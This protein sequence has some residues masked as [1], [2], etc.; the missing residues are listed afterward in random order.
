MN[1]VEGDT[2]SAIDFLKRFH[3]SGPW[4]LTAIVPDGMISTITF[5]PSDEGAAF[6]WIESKQGSHNLYFSVNRVARLLKSK[7]VKEDIAFLDY[8]HVDAD[9]RVGEDHGSERERIRALFEA[10]SPRPTVV[11][12]SGGGY[13]AFWKL[14]TPVKLN[15]DLILIGELEAYNR[16]LELELQGDN[17]FNV[18]RI[19]RLCGTVNVPNKKKIAKGRQ[20]ALSKLV[21]AEWERTYPLTAFIPA[22][23]LQSKSS[24]GPNKR[25]SV[26]VPANVK[27]ITSVDEL[28]DKVRDIV[29]R[30]I[31][32]GHDPDNPSRWPSRSECLFFVVC[33]LVRAELDDETIA[34]VLLD[35]DFGISASVYDA[36]RPENYVARQIERAREVAVDPLLAEFNDQYAVVMD[37]GGKCR[38]VKDLYDEALLRTYISYQD[39]DNFKNG[40]R[41]KKVVV[42]KDKN[43]GDVYKDAGT[44]WT[45]HPMRRTFK[46]LGFVPGREVTDCY[47]LWRGFAC[48]AR[49]GD[50]SLYLAHVKDNICSGNE[51]H[52]EYLLSWM[53]RTVQKLAAQGEVAVVLRGRKGAGKG[54]FVH[55]FGKVL[56][57]HYMAI[58]DAKHLVGS[59][60]SHLRDCILLFADEAFYAGDKRHESNLKTL[61]TEETRPIEAKGVD[62]VT[63]PNYTRLVIASNDKWVVPVDMDERRFLVLDV[64]DKK[65]QD[66]KYF[67]A[68]RKQME[69]GGREALLH[70]L[71]SRD[72]AEFE[73]R[74]APGS[75]ALQEQKAFSRTPEEMWWYERLMDGTILPEHMVWE[76]KVQ[77]KA[78]ELS[79]SIFL[80]Q[81]NVAGRRL[82]P[83]RLQ[84]ALSAYLDGRYPRQS[85]EFGKE[86]HIGYDNKVEWRDG[87]PIMWRFPSL[88]DAR[89]AWDR[90][91]RCKTTWPED[92]G[93]ADDGAPPP[94]GPASPF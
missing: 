28:G 78:V 65:M 69:T 53:A 17:C 58:S 67:G 40:Y 4:C 63:A 76:P 70:V 42:G 29:K 47:N 72:I 74:L 50:C 90:R 23:K 7:A 33:E 84:A 10:Y 19:M 54:V 16:Q 59:F 39:F 36:Q 75:E 26:V 87:R 18:D 71:L 79:Y 56:G 66:H 48:E 61:I 31:V 24:A 86:L 94:Q 57:R 14:D 13:Q 2:P 83:T 81:L 93:P 68:I 88:A 62:V 92:D 25:G 51:E 43:G 9:P 38:V 55:E 27:R 91:G 80:R 8:L 32:Q 89:A 73:V 22:P 45:E 35:R 30:I 12:D 11:V 5:N 15:A 6:K 34:A 60:N 82:A 41:N 21:W 46:T 49:K 37:I 85:R 3:P 52:Y 64:N 20:P 77:R 44:W 1:S